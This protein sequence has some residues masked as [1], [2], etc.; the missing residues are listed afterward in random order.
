LEQFL[1][2]LGQVALVFGQQGGVKWT[3]TIRIPQ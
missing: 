1:V 3:V 2:G